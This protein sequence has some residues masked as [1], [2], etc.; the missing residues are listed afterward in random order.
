[1]Y[2]PKVW[3]Q[4]QLFA[5]SAL[6]GD[7]YATNNFVGML[8]GD[9]LGVRFYSK[10]IRELAIVGIQTKSL[11]FKAVTGD[12]ICAVTAEQEENIILYYDSNTIIGQVSSNACAV[13]LVEGKTKYFEYDQLEI[14]DTGDGEVTA[15]A[16]NG[17]KFSFA[18]G[19][20]HE[21]VAK[22]ALAGLN[23]DIEAEVNKKLSYYEKYSLP[24]SY[25]YHELYSKCLSVM[26]TQLYSPEGKFP[27]IWSTPDRL[28]HRNLWL[29]DSVFHALGFRH[30]DIKLA[31]GLV[32][33]IFPNQLD[34]GMI[35]HHA[36]VGWHSEISQPPVIAWGAW[37][38]YETS[39]NIEF[40]KTVFKHNKSFLEWCYENRRCL[41]QVL[42]TWDTNEEVFNRCDESGIDNSPRFDEEVRLL[43]IDFAC[44]MAN[45]MRYM[46]KIAERIGED[47]QIYENRFKEI[48]DA[49][50]KMLWDEQDGFYY[51]YNLDTNK[52]HKV[53]SMCSFL[54]LFA[55]LCDEKQA[56]R[57]VSWLTDP[58][59]F[60]TEM[61]VPSISKRDKHFAKDMWRS[62]V[63]IN[64]NYMIIAGL[65]DYGYTDLAEDLTEKTIKVVNEWYQKTGVVFEFY[66]CENKIAPY[67]LD[68]KGTI[69]EPYNIRI[70]LQSVRDFGW[71]NTLISDLIISRK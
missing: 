40:L 65:I 3:G 43:A 60:Y 8:S 15:L 58:E 71:S 39:G 34:N 4:G 29:W 16:V 14:Q 21:D 53:E 63:W 5:F 55:G 17:N 68:R 36:K 59:T 19:N 48:K 57:L 7:A 52:L 67:K 10:I 32:L 45:E 38:L 51:D 61:P 37:K 20:N 2:I 9:K 26:K 23:A 27:Y 66:D 47:S 62:P 70:K 64:F 54:P 35:P 49:V 46:S 13:V 31:E 44:Y 42:F 69:V 6:D 24:E 1:M 50:N 25:K 41:D 30:M 56:E 22:K 12:Y 33:D 18:Y 11:E 28:P